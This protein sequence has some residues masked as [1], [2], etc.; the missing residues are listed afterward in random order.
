LYRG[1]VGEGGM[2]KFIK[3]GNGEVIHDGMMDKKT[4]ELE[5]VVQ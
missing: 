2:V 3:Y 1:R 4:M 5:K